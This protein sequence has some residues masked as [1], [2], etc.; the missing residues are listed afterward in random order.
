MTLNPTVDDVDRLTVVGEVREALRGLMDFESYAWDE[1][2]TL[3]LRGRLSAPGCRS[4]PARGSR[5]GGGCA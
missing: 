4:P 1:R 3:T 2:G 5:T